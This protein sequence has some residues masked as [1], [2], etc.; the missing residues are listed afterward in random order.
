MLDALLSDLKSQ[1]GLFSPYAFKSQR[2]LARAVAGAIPSAVA[3]V[4]G[5]A[6]GADAQRYGHTMNRRSGYERT[7]MSEKGA[8][9]RNE[10]TQGAMDNRL[11]MSLKNARNMQANQ[12][13]YGLAAQDNQHSQES[14][15]AK[16]YNMWNDTRS[17]ELMQT[18]TGNVN[19][20]KEKKPFVFDPSDPVGAAIQPPVT[21]EEDENGVLDTGVRLY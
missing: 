12:H 20:K 18:L 17:N 9:D 1:S 8:T 16:L 6:M 3:N 11:E 4:R 19:S 7:A 14:Y 5:S 21:Q 13:K 15:L 10:Y 2:K